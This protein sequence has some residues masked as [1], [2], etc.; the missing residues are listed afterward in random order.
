[1]PFSAVLSPTVPSHHAHPP[2]LPS[3]HTTTCLTTLTLLCPHTS[4]LDGH[5]S[6]CL[7]LLCPASISHLALCFLH[8]ATTLLPLFYI[9]WFVSA[10]VYMREASYLWIC[11]C[12]LLLTPPSLIL[13]YSLSSPGINISLSLPNKH[14]PCPPHQ[15]GWV[16]RPAHAAAS[17]CLTICCSPLTSLASCCAASLPPLHAAFTSQHSLCSCLTCLH[18]PHAFCTTP[19][20]SLTCLP[21]HTSTSRTFSPHHG[22]I[23]LYTTTSLLPSRTGWDNRWV[24][25]CPPF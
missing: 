3:L 13:S 21:H 9:N 18:A 19:R 10:W 5:L 23:L 6:S 4:H 11:A 14:H 17:H 8:L 12:L 16:G 24:K 25:G 15:Q 7:P 20:T 1:V 22:R 2:P